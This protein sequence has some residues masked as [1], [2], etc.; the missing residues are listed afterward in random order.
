[1][2]RPPN[3]EYA[4]AALMKGFTPISRNQ[5]RPFSGIDAVVQPSIV[6]TSAVPGNR[7][8]VRFKKDLRF[9]TGTPSGGFAY[10]L[11]DVHPTSLGEYDND[12]GDWKLQIST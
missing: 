2:L 1:M 6:E 5:S 11:R 9:A 10:S 12:P 4:A 3:A 8:A 7:N